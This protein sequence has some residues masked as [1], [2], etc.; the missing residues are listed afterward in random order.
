MDKLQ[1][2]LK[3]MKFKRCKI[4]GLDEED[5]LEHIKEICDLAREELEEQAKNF[6]GLAGKTQ[7][8]S[9]E[10]QPQQGEMEQQEDTQD[11]A[12]QERDRCRAIYQ[13]LLVAVD[14]LRNVNVE[15][16]KAARQEMRM[17]L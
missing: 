16:E 1:E 3:A 15:A 9:D 12:E 5:V 14:A 8:G 11:L 6:S 13:D 7:E 4:G 10:L 17:E 2:Y